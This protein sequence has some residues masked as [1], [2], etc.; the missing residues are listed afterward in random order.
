MLQAHPTEPT[1]VFF[2]LYGHGEQIRILFGVAK[3]PYV[4]K[5]IP[6]DQWPA[7]KASGQ[8]PLG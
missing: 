8:L 7:L 3:K 1:F 4:D 2:D 6:M 5:R